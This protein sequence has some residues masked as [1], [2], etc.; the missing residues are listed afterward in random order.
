MHVIAG[1]GLT[2]ITLKGSYG[3]PTAPYVDITHTELGADGRF[4]TNG[5]KVTLHWP[6]EGLQGMIS[7]LQEVQR[8]IDEAKAHFLA[9]QPK[10]NV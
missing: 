2:N 3:G 10:E 6:V 4:T 8:M 5:A 1:W 7:Q 9:S